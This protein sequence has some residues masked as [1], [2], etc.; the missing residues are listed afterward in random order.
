MT[1]IRPKAYVWTDVGQKRE[2]NEDAYLL[3][4]EYDLYAVADGMGGHVGGE[5]ASQLATQSIKELVL[6]NLNHIDH[7]EAPKLL[8][9]SVR[10]ASKRIF[11]ETFVHPELK[12]MGTT[13]TALLLESEQAILAHVGDSRAYLIREGELEQ[14][15]EDHSLVQEQFRS[16]L[17]SLEQARHSRF[18]NIITRC[19]G[20]ED[21][22]DVDMMVLTP[23][24]DDIFVLCT[25]G[26]TTL[27]ED[28]EI[29]QTIANNDQQ[30]AGQKLIDLA[31]SRGGNDNITVL[32]VYV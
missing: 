30:I 8:G 24:P 25:D 2:R 26:L 3:L 7:A 23:Q 18:R 1:R 9:D 29:L 17:I 21:D 22:V 15:T 19:L 28:K 13:A 10:A 31:N 5:K 6:E 27:V 4:P 11:E 12:G 16:G 14:I 20:F 32:L